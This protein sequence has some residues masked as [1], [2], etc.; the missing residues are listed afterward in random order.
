MQR[1]HGTSDSSEDSDLTYQEGAWPAWAVPW[2][3]PSR[4]ALISFLVI[5]FLLMIV[6]A[7]PVLAAIPAVVC[8]GCNAMVLRLDDR[9]LRPAV[10]DAVP[11]EWSG[12]TATSEHV[13][14]YEAAGP[15]QPGDGPQ[16]PDRRSGPRDRRSGPRERRGTSGDRES[17]PWDGPESPGRSE[18]G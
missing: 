11:P 13:Q 2:L 17:R 16:R 1:D 12:V 7:P 15:D 6:G 10:P 3:R 4:V 9:Q 18:G 8:A 5:W 14:P